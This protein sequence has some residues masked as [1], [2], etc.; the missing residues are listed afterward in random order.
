[1]NDNRISPMGFFAGWAVGVVLAGYTPLILPF[2]YSLVLPAAVLI[3]AMCA[4][5]LYLVLRAVARQKPE[6]PQRLSYPD[7]ASAIAAGAALTESN[8]EPYRQRS[9]ERRGIGVIEI[10]PLSNK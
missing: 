8:L 2:P 1:M 7:A 6:P 9:H 5:G 4:Y 10:D 3:G